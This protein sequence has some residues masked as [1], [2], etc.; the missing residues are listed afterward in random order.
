MVKKLTH[1][2]TLGRNKL[3]NDVLW[4]INEFFNNKSKFREGIYLTF[5]CFLEIKDVQ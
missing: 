5:P 1:Y 3:K 2:Y 4:R